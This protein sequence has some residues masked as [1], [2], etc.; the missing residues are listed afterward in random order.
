M[1]FVHPPRMTPPSQRT[2][3]RQVREPRASTRRS[4]HETVTARHRRG[5]GRRRHRPRDP[6]FRRQ[7]TKPYLTVGSAA[8]T[9]LAS[10]SATSPFTLSGCGY[11][12]L[13]T[14]IVWHN[15]TGPYQEVTPD[16]N[17]CISAAF[18][19]FGSDPTGSY[20]GQAWQQQGT[21]W[22]NNPYASV[23][24]TVY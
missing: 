23:S 16:A 12:K 5:R 19:A 2:W 15:S 10:L 9:S 24:F 3:S 22:E 13:T 21:G 1:T 6:G 8:S 11:T 20:T 17:G 4:A 18:S 14:I 7:A